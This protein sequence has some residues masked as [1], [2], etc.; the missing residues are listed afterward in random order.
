MVAGY[1]PLQNNRINGVFQGLLDPRTMPKKLLFSQRVNQVP[2]D[3]GE[4]MARFIG[5]VHIADLIA[6]DQRAAV[7]SAGKFQY[8][9]QNIP[10]LKVGQSMSQAMLNQWQAIANN[11]GISNIQVDN[12]SNAEAR[13]LG[14]VLTGVRYRK[15]QLIAAM[16]MDGLSY[17]RLG[18]QMSNV[19]WGM[20]ID[21]KVNASVNWNDPVNARPTDDIYGLKLVAQTRYDI[22]YNRLTMST[23]TFRLMISTAEFQNKA[24]TF[25]APNVSYVN[26]PLANLQQQQDIAANVLGMTIELYDARYASQDTRGAYTLRPFLDLNAVIFS[27]TD[28][29]SDSSAV[30]FANGITTESLV[31]SMAGEPIAGGP[32]FG[33]IAYPTFPES[34]NPP[35][36]VY[37]GV[38]RGFPRKHL[39]QY[40]ACMRV[41]PVTDQIPVQAPF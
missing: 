37:W 1:T 29:D 10:N 19:T 17:N 41:G 11:T 4:I 28:L 33:P 15:E 21:L 34:L 27:S 24:R 35:N 18:I 23:P 7:Y 26:L 22:V 6:D 8:E 40:N 2:A 5:Y 32:A 39:L 12:F 38:Q 16:L 14:N 13:L 31:A 20:P 30:D 3:D 36:I 25:L 9:Q